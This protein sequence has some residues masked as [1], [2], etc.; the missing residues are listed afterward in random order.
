MLTFASGHRKTK[1][2]CKYVVKKLPFV[3]KYVPDQYKTKKMCHKVIIENL[4]KLIHLFDFTS[5]GLILIVLGYVLLYLLDMSL[6][7][8]TYTFF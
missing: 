3:T 2:I 6:S 4:S 5:V 8:S 1:K 7:L